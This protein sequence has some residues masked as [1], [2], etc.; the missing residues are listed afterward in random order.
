MLIGKNLAGAPNS[1]NFRTI[2]N[3]GLNQ[4]GYSGIEFGYQGTI[5]MY[6][7]NAQTFAN[8]TF[9]D[10]ALRFLISGNGNVRV[11]NLSGLG[12]RLVYSTSDGTLTNSSSDS[13]MKRNVNTINYGL[14]EIL[15]LRPVFY[16]WINEEKLGSRKEIGFI[17]QEML[18]VIP[19]VIGTNMDGTYSLDYPKL[20]A[21]LTKGIQEQQTQISTLSQD[22]LTLSS[23][24]TNL[25]SAMQSLVTSSS[26]LESVNGNL[27]L[28]MNNLIS[29]Q[30]SF[31][32]RLNNFSNALGNIT[33]TQSEF[34]LSLNTLNLKQEELSTA[35]G[36]LN[37][38][39]FQSM[40][41]SLQNTLDALTM[42]TLNGELVIS[43]DLLV[44]GDSIF[45]N[46]TFTGD[47]SIGQ[48][49]FNTLDNS[50]NVL[51][52]SC[53]N[54]DNTLNDTLCTSQTLYVMKNTSGYIDFFDGRITF[55]PNGDLEVKRVVAQ[56]VQ[57]SEYKVASTSEISGT[58]VIDS[59]DLEILILSDKVK[60][61]S[62]IFV[63]ATT[64]LKGKSLFVAEK[65][66]E[67]SFKVK[68]NEISDA[69]IHFDWFIL[70]ME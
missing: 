16:N 45:N 58:G 67:I 42:D 36:S 31:E 59:G 8:Q 49:S 7:S 28:A 4:G 14:N 53:V 23:V 40:Y 38:T 62:K 11:A 69:D 46:A 41:D 22:S 13:G 51:G 60:S 33:M 19:E 34:S 24:S 68:L 39:T 61:N 20:T 3:A 5:L 18:T 56:E 6:A 65:I 47:V 50:L 9:A 25:S 1:D 57:A 35:L 10:A 54:L 55:K 43:S 52:A 70:N 63:T 21:L 37:L 48:M 26:N 12:N 66:S 44:N 2:V 64:D 30:A 29:T 32:L 15:Q 17:A 27:S